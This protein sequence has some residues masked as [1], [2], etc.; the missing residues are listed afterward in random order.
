MYNNMKWLTLERIK[1]NSRIDDDSEDA[2]LELYGESAEET[3]LNI[4][5]RSY[6]E[7]VE[8]YGDVPKALIHASLMLVDLSYQQRMPISTQNLYVMPYTFDVLVKP[9]MRLTFSSENNKSQY[10]KHCNL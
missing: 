8:T 3:V 7:V 9:Y 10:G 2:L 5:D 6:E 4:I 1:Q